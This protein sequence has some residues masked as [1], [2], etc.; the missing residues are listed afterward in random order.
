MKNIRPYQ[1][2]D[3]EAVDNIYAAA[4]MD[5]FV[6]ETVEFSFL[7]LAEDPKRLQYLRESKIFV[8]ETDRVIGYCAY[9]ENEIRA[10]FVLPA[11]RKK[12]VGRN[13]FEYMLSD[14]SGLP[15]LYVVKSNA[16]AKRFYVRYGFEV[17]AEFETIYNRKKVVANRMEKIG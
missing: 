15:F 16:D 7:P 12:G 1:E 8:Y 9:L 6:H 3:Q 13:M 4:K 10:L 11:H 2:S 5:E 17:V 14:I